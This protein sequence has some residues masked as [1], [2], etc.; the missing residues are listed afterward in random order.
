LIFLRSYDI[1]VP[2]AAAQLVSWL[3]AIRT[4]VRTPLFN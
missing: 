1:T 2:L 4:F 3:Q